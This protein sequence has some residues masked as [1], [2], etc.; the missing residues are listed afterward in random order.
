MNLAK[1]ISN[2]SSEEQQLQRLML[3]NSYTKEAAEIRIKAQMPLP[4]KCKLCTHIIDNSGSIEITEKQVRQLY[5]E[6]DR[7][8]AYWKIRILVAI[9]ASSIVGL[10][11]LLYHHIVH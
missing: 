4:E 9:C 5:S 3:R 10:G 7:C 2:F 6:F 11:L 1:K 8:K